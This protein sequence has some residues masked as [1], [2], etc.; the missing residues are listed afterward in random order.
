MKMNLRA[1][2]DQFAAAWAQ[3][4]IEGCL[5]LM[6]V[7]ARYGAS[8]GPEPGR[9]FTGTGALRA[10]IAG[11]GLEHSGRGRGRCAA[12]RPMSTQASPGCLMAACSTLAANNA[13]STCSPMR[14]RPTGAAAAGY[15]MPLSRLRCWRLEPGLRRQKLQLETLL[16]LADTALALVKPDRSRIPC[17]RLPFQPIGTSLAGSLRDLFE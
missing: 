16:E 4:D 14:R 12:C 5:A 10:G 13:R 17:R 15:T 6:T 1:I 3:G 9:T 8:I 11:Q 7:D 2:Y